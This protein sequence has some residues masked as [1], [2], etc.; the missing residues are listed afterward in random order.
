MPH[1]SSGSPLGCLEGLPRC[2]G[3]LCSLWDIEQVRCTSRRSHEAHIWAEERARRRREGFTLL[4][5][6]I[7]LFI[8]GVLMMVGLP[9]LG[10]AIYHAKLRSDQAVL[11]NVGI[12]ICD[13]AFDHGNDVSG[14]ANAGPLLPGS[15]AAAELQ[16]YIK[17]IPSHDSWGGQFYLTVGTT[18]EGVRAISGAT[19]SDWI[20][21]AFGSDHLE[22]PHP[23]NYDP[24]QPDQGF[25]YISKVADFENDVVLFDGDFIGGPKSLVG[26]GVEVTPKPKGK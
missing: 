12:A 11:R 13:Y 16:A 14:L 20:L 19:V 8:I 9:A 15:T 24:S 10:S 5:M 23:L 6:S 7:A 21:E 1:D 25:W 17:I 2:A 3:H 4:E 26:T 18:C 22:G